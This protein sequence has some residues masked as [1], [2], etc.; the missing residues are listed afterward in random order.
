MSS[1]DVMSSKKAGTNTGL[2]SVKG[3]KPSFSSRTRV[4]RLVFEP[5]SENWQGPGHTAICQLSIRHSIIL[6]VICL[7]TPKAGSSRTFYHSSC[8]LPTDSQGRLRSNIL[9]FLL[10]T[11]RLPKQAPVEQSDEQFPPLRAHRHTHALVPSVT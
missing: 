4:P 3:Q 9:S 11:Y 7:Q 2:Y 1:Q 10:F 6:P 5:V 8:S